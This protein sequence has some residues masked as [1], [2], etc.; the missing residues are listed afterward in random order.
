MRENSFHS[1]LNLEDRF[2]RIKLKK[3]KTKKTHKLL[4]AIA[5][6]ACE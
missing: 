5:I 6:T 2:I 3:Q 4:R 1:G